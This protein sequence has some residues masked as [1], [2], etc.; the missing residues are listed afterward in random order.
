MKHLHKCIKQLCGAANLNK[1]FFI[2]M[3][4]LQHLRCSNILF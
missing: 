2:L 3:T 1:M 4:H